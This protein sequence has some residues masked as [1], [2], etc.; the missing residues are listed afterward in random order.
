MAR[1][2]QPRLVYL[3]THVVMWL[4]DGLTDRLSPRAMKEI[5]RGQLYVSPMAELEIQYLHEIGRFRPTAEE[6]CDLLAADLGLQ[7]SDP[8]FRAVVQTARALLW[9][10]DP[11]ARLIVAETLLSGAHLIT[12]DQTIRKHCK[13]AVW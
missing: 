4:H 13:R 12:K 9:T 5:E 8:S 2:G 6:A 10:R 3:D 1:T 11:F 7:R